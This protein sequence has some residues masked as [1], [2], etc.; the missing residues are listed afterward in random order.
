MTTSP[1]HNGI[2]LPKHH[3]VNKEEEGSSRIIRHK[4]FRQIKHVI[5]RQRAAMQIMKNEKRKKKI[6]INVSLV[7]WSKKS[8]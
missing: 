5:C 3:A 2:S 8:D 1:L 7:L 6:L 4:R